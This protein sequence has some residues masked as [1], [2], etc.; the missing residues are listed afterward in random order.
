[1]WCINKRQNKS[2]KQNPN[3]KLIFF[4]LSAIVLRLSIHILKTAQ[5]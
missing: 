4:K 5:K 3:L 1:M 2:S